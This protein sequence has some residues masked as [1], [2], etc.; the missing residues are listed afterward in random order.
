MHRNPWTM[1]EE[2]RKQFYEDV[3]SMPFNE[4]A[5][6]DLEEIRQARKKKKLET[7]Q[8]KYE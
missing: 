1:P 6:K 8:V 5:M 4:M 7:K 3:W 2:D